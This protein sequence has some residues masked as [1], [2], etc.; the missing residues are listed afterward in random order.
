M[1]E[2]E[3]EESRDPLICKA[4]KMARR[5]PEQSISEHRGSAGGL[6]SSSSEGLSSF[7]LEDALVTL[8]R[9]SRVAGP[10][11]DPA[12]TLEPPLSPM[13]SSRRADM[14]GPGVIGPSVASVGFSSVPEAF[15]QVERMLPEFS[16]F[17][18]AVGR[19]LQ[20]S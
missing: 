15:K 19:L 6:S 14:E 4:Q 5:S 12:E 17:T 2:E 20:D 18:S 7:G 8:K 3:E 9:Q 13:V 1:N 16:S 10:S 11:A